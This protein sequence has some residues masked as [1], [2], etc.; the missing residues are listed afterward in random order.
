MM[1]T[2]VPPVVHPSLGQMA[3]IHGVAVKEKIRRV[4][5][6]YTYDSEVLILKIHRYI[7]IHIKIRKKRKLREKFYTIYKFYQIIY[8][9]KEAMQCKRNTKKKK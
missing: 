3:F 5:Y 9:L 6:L 7:D 1:I 4:T 8:K 2:V